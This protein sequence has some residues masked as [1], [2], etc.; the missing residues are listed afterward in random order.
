MS[1]FIDEALDDPDLQVTLILNSPGD[2]RK[3]FTG[4][5]VAPVSF[6]SSAD[7]AVRG[8]SLLDNAQAAKETVEGLAG[9]VDID[10]LQKAASRSQGMSFRAHSLTS[11]FWTGS[12]DATLSVIFGMLNNQANPDVFGDHYELSALLYPEL[13]RD[14]TLLPPHGYRRS[15]RGEN[16]QGTWTLSIGRYFRADGLLLTSVDV[17]PSFELDG[18]QRR[19]S[20]IRSVVTCSFTTNKTTTVDQVKAWYRNR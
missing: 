15:A 2:N 10:F 17:D 16:V 18:T 12:S 7:Y 14:G 3:A 9:A 1:Y 19:P 11:K 8:Q 6:N 20:P 13:S 5:Q 4:I